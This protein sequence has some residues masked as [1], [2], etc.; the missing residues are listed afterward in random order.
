MEVLD[1]SPIRYFILL[2]ISRIANRKGL[3]K[4]KK[5][6]RKVEGNLDFF[7]SLVN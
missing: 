5:D 3:Y 4:Q 2:Q 1:E 6:W 7:Q